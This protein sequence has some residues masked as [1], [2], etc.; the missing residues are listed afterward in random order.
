MKLSP[1]NHDHKS[2]MNRR[3]SMTAH[4]FKLFF[5]LVELLIVNISFIGSLYILY[6][7][8]LP[9]FKLNLSD[10]LSAAPLLTLAALLYIDYFGMT[11]FFRKNQTDVIASAGQF[12][13]LVT[14]TSAAIAFVFQWFMFSR[15]AMALGALLMFVLTSIWSIVCLRISKV[16]YTKGKLLIIAATPEDADRLYLKVRSEQ[17]TLHITYLGYALAD[18]LPRLFKLISHSTEVMVSS[19]VS[20][21][22]RSQLFLYCAN[23]DKTIYVVPQFSDLVYTKFRIIQFQDMPTFMIDSLG[24]TFQ[25]RLLKR[26]FD[27]VFSFIA[28]IL[29]SP[30]LLFIAIVVRLDSHGPALYSQERITKSGK[31][32]KVYKFRTMV[33]AAEEKF[34]AYQSSLDDP[35]VT[36]IGKILRNTHL[37]ELPQ[38]I[39][40]LKGDLSVVGP[41]SDR[42][43]T[44]GEFEENIPGYHQRLK[45]KAGLTGLAQ[46]Y[47]KYNSD[48]E[49]KLSFDMMYIKN[50]SFLSDMK[51]IIQTVK[52]MLP[53]KNDYVVQE[54][55]CKNWEFVPKPKPNTPQ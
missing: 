22:D 53:S 3:H 47:G 42:P 20:E 18:D 26:S 19:A 21:S 1:K 17:R 35:R 54:E 41:R 29:T 14:V 40:I 37:D 16:I 46:I 39:N 33:D 36:K 43:T 13:F 51:I 28:L 44:V 27:V 49:D 4:L 2:M 12:T 32:Y 9:T 7:P 30:F 25:Q 52:T 6:N 50:Y 45:V 23:V 48:P 38:F 10:Y 55:D 5:I 8:K 15:W 34:G 24:L 11:H 31:I